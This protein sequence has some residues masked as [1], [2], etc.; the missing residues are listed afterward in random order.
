MSNHRVWWN[1]HINRDIEATFS[2]WMKDN[3]SAQRYEKKNCTKVQRV[4]DVS[5]GR[6]S[7]FHSGIGWVSECKGSCFSG[8]GQVYT[9]KLGTKHDLLKQVHTRNWFYPCLE[10][11]LPVDGVAQEREAIHPREVA[12]AEFMEHGQGFV[13]F[14]CNHSCTSSY[15]CF[16][17]SVLCN[18][19]CKCSSSSFSNKTDIKNDL[20]SV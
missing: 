15:K 3:T 19:R 11:F 7:C 1:W 18:G 10:N 2:Y 4:Y 17:S 13:N 9:Y 12:I 8:V 6:K 14:S 5:C 16:K 20:C